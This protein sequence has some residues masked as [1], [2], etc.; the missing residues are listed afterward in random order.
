MQMNTPTCGSPTP[1]DDLGPVALPLPK[2]AHGVIVR[3]KGVGG[4]SGYPFWA[5]LS[6]GWDRNENNKRCLPKHITTLI[7]A[8]ALLCC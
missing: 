1:L 7:K 5:C 6:E 8:V 4:V 3:I 2:L